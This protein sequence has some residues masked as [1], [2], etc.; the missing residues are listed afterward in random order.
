MECEMCGK[1]VATRRFMVDGT[2]MQLGVCCARYGTA[3]DTPQAAPAGSKAAVQQNLERRAS[4][5]KT[6]DI[7]AEEVWDLVQD[8]GR[9]IREARERNGWSHDQLGNKV[10][11]RVPQLRQ[12]E[13]NHLRPSDELAK[14]FEKE[15][16]ITLMEKVEGKA[17]AVSGAQKGSGAGLTIGDLLRD[18]LQKK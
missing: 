9:R 16:G 3:L 5:M 10:S 6:K 12:I 18:A 15:L 2:I 8:F 4:R 13:A 1:K 7:Y 17:P 11:A 14:K